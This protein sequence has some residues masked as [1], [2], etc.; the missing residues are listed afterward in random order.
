MKD[1]MKWVHLLGEVYQKADGFSSSLEERSHL[2]QRSSEFGLAV[3]YTALGWE[4]G[5]RSE[6]RKSM[7]T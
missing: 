4:G 6:M 7:F 3:F 2:A 5:M 1:I